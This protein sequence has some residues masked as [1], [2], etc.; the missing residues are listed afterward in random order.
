MSHRT[1][2]GESKPAASIER[3]ARGIKR[4]TGRQGLIEATADVLRRGDEVQIT[5]VAASVGV[6]HTLVYRHFPQGGKDE[7]VAEAYAYLFAGLASSDIDELFTALA[8]AR[9]RTPASLRQ[10]ISGFVLEVLNP[11]RAQT[12]WA[13]LEAL[14]QAR[15]NPYVAERIAAARVGLVRTFADRLLDFEPALGEEDALALSLLS[16][17]MPLG[18]TAI[19]GP[20]LPPRQRR[21]VA[22]MWADAV[23]HVLEQARSR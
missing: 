21:T 1:E 8:S 23:V 15:T 17:A 4:G 20:A 12:R 9:P 5:E 7:M 13:R 10:V 11:A 2:A 18:L 6:S 3:R 19:A 16:Q 14:A 22:S